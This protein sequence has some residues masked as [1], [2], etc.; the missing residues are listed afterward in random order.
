M[1]NDNGNVFVL[2]VFLMFRKIF[3]V[4]LGHMGCGDGIGNVANC[5]QPGR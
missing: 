2:Y 5:F 3:N 1:N 4:F